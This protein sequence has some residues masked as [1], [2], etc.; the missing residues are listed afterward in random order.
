MLHEIKN[1]LK[2]F[3]CSRFLSQVIGYMTY[4]DTCYDDE[5]KVGQE[6]HHLT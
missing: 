6:K 5:N 2:S 3:S 4:A 1:Q